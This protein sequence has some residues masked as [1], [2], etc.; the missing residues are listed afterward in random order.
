MTFLSGL[1]V[2]G[3]TLTLPFTGSAQGDRTAASGGMV[4]VPAGSYLPLYTVDGRPVRLPAFELD[5]DAV[6][7]ADYLEFVRARPEWRRGRVKSLFAGPDYLAD[8]QGDLD[9][10]AAATGASRVTHVSWFAAK[11]YCEWV[12]KRLPTTDEWEYAA[13]A[14]ETHRDASRDR[15]FIQ[16]LMELYT[17]PAALRKSAD[18]FRNLYGVYGLHGEGGEWVLDFNN[19]LVSDDSRGA[20]GHDRLLYCAAGGVATTDPSNYPAFLRF[21]MRASL[22]GNSVVRNMGFRCARSIQ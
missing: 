12:G 22:Q 4:R 10:G 9:P 14:S 19:L 21:A 16:R 15:E 13:A 17:R 6:T 18:R 8:W 3:L 2:A 5:R 1:L 11:S 20:G 7:R